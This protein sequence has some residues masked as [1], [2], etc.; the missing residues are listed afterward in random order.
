MDALGKNEIAKPARRR[1]L[2]NLYRSVEKLITSEQ[3]LVQQL[4]TERDMRKMGLLGSILFQTTPMP[5]DF[6]RR[7][8]EALGH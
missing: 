7:E 5:E 3:Q 2:D 1:S 6:L 4:E 8:S